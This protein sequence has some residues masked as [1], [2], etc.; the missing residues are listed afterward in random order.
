MLFIYAAVG[1]LWFLA[2]HLVFWKEVA[3][4]WWWEFGGDALFL[5][6]SVF[7]M[8]FCLVKY[9]R[10][11]ER[12]Q[13]A[14]RVA[15]ER[16]RAVLET[17][18][19]AIHLVGP[20]GKL[21]EANSAFYRSLGYDPA[22]VPPLSVEDWDARLESEEIANKIA[23]ILDRTQ[24]FETRHRHTN[25]T[26]REVEVT[27]TGITL[28]G[29]RLALCVARD[30]SG[31]NQLQNARLR[32]ER[33]ESLGLLA[34]GIA[35]DLNNALAPIILGAEL[36][37]ARHPDPDG[38]DH[39]LLTSMVTSAQRGAGIIRQLLTFARGIDGER[40]PVPV[41]PLMAG[42][43][44]EAERTFPA[45]VRVE[46]EMAP[47]LPPVRGDAA[48]LHQVML[49]LAL[50]AR[51]AMPRGGRLVLGARGRRVA[52]GE[53][54]GLGNTDMLSIV[55]LSVRDTGTGLSR[56][57]REHLFEPFFTTKPRGQGT[58]LG[59][60]TALGI[61]RSHGG[62]IECH[63]PPDGGTEFRVLLPEA[64][65]AEAMRRGA[66]VGVDSHRAPELP[67][68]EPGPAIPRVA[69][70]SEEEK[71]IQGEGRL[72]MVVEDD[73]AVR[74][75]T[76]A[77]LERHG[78]QVVEASDGISALGMLTL[79]GRPPAL[80]LTDLMMPRLAGDELAR[81]VHERMPG[82][83]IVAMTGLHS[84]DPNAP[85]VRALLASGELAGLLEKPFG[86][87]RLLEEIGRVLAATGRAPV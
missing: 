55:E 48:Q 86:E 49:S 19:D 46:L 26:L 20:D 85:Q 78:F 71:P 18:L 58:G 84:E 56:E 54:E 43:V 28:E 22:T 61:V 33:L 75:S 4:D 72:I 12:A 2:S 57:A 68:V 17:S 16:Y 81:R 42:L 9:R 80:V 41:R 38:S 29:R 8:G 44:N 69:A 76:C 13:Q 73:L 79:A 32:A 52:P 62:T 10:Q 24:V 39:Q 35:H 5:G 27:A 1:A 3:G 30:I 50:N 77:V 6:V 66:R 65:A 64:G 67:T 51:D 31:R 47:G 37:Q 23:T 53:I 11:A 60:S 45:G 15:A 14:D 74:F 25:G 40:L 87:K 34:G 59:L 21:V 82:L 83:P 7:T 36:L 63:Q 70:K